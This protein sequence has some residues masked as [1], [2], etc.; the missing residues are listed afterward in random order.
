MKT[1]A[2]GKTGLRVSRLSI[3]TDYRNVY[4]QPEAGARILRRGFELGINFWDTAEDYGAHPAIREALRHLDRSEVVI[5]TKTYGSGNAEVWESLEKSTKEMGTDYL[6]AYLLH[7]VDSPEE[8]EGRSSALKAML[9]AKR[10][11]LIRAVGLSTH[12]VSVARAALRLPEIE[13]V[14]A[15]VN[16][17]GARIRE[18]TLAGMLEALRDLYGARR[19]VYIMK[20][21]GRGILSGDVKG[22]LTYVLRVPYAHS[23]SVGIASLEEL[24]EDVRIAEEAL[25]LD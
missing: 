23:V 13:V 3:G 8:I 4:G 5:A 1:V 21:L 9:E 10:K 24:E 6:D 18:G 14:L 22:A 11:G 15:V 2:L 12:S 17:T 25:R 7:A 19:G 16:R 20:P